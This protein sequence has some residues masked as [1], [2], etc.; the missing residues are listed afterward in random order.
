MFVNNRINIIRHVIEFVAFSVLCS[1]NR[2]FS[3]NN[4]SHI[5]LARKGLYILSYFLT[6]SSVQMRD[7]LAKKR[8]VN[9][10]K[11]VLT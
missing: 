1:F 11:I 4:L 5:R 10:R 9:S 8:S 6:M 3:R 2:I 7:C